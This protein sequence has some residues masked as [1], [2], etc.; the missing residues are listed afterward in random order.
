MDCSASA[1]LT[2]VR[3]CLVS[4]SDTWFLGIIL[5]TV[6]LFIGAI[7]EYIIEE[8]RPFHALLKLTTSG[9][10]IRASKRFCKDGEMV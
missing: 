2:A 10:G 4:I 1:S 5:S 7:A 8:F 6:I 9:G 3:D